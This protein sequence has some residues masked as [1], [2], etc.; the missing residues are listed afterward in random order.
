MFAQDY[1]AIAEYFTDKV[2]VQKMGVQMA[3][4]S[5]A[6]KSDAEAFFKA[7]TALNILG[8]PTKEEAVTMLEARTAQA[9]L[10]AA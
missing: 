4:P 2:R 8:Y 6:S 5:S 10:R 7:R 1:E 9:G 3:T